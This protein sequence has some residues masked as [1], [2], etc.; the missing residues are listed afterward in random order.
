MAP[1][2]QALD[3]SSS[4]GQIF[5]P[6]LLFLPTLGTAEPAHPK[7][8]I[9]II[10]KSYHLHKISMDSSEVSQK[11]NGKANSPNSLFIQLVTVD[12]S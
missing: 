10:Y 12:C 2:S 4:N 9:W 11:T 3:F 8:V 6:Y 1:F 5:Q 7:V